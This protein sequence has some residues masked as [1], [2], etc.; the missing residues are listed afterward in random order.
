M[1]G[2]RAPL[3]DAPLTSLIGCGGGRTSI[4]SRRLS[5]PMRS[6]GNAECRDGARRKRSAVLQWDIDRYSQLQDAAWD[7]DS[8]AAEQDR[9][10]RRSGR[11][12]EADVSR[13]R[14]GALRQQAADLLTR[15]WV[16]PRPGV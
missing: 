4:C 1:A 2:L 6:A 14:A 3:R 9:R 16:L 7:L 13:A 10:A 5:L 15:Y 8:C 12:S 11:R